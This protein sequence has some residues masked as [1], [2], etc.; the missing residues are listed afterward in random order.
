MKFKNRIVE[1][2]VE[3][4][5]VDEPIKEAVVVEPVEEPVVEKIDSKPTKFEEH[6]QRAIKNYRKFA[7]LEDDAQ[8]DIDNLDKD[9]IARVA[10]LSRTD[11]D[12][13]VEWLKESV[14]TEGQA[15][16]I[17]DMVNAN[18][19]ETISEDDSQG[20][21]EKTLDRIL[22]ANLRIN[23]RGGK[24]FINVLFE[25]AAGTGKTARIEEWAKKNS[26]NLVKV[27]AKKLDE[28]DFG[29]LNYN[30]E[31][32]Y[33]DKVRTTQ[34]DNLDKPR[35]V[36]FLDELNRA[37]QNIRATLLT[38]VNNH[39]I[40]DTKNGGSKYFENYLFTIAAINPYSS[41]YGT[42]PL[43][44]AE[45]S[46]Y[47]TIPVPNEIKVAK[48]YYNKYYDAAIEAGK[49]AGDDQAVL[50]DEGRKAIMNKLLDD[51]NFTFDDE[52]DE[53]EVMQ[54]GNQKPLNLRSFMKCL[55]ASDGTKA[56]FLSIWKN[57]CNDQKY[58]D[59]V[60][61]LKDYTDVADKANAAIGAGEEEKPKSAFAGK[62]DLYSKIYGNLGKN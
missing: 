29:V 22:K 39:E 36:L 37:N 33:A 42:K 15:E 23:S 61:I 19:D 43:D 9:V 56:D 3:T 45:Q 55:E 40:E 1:S 2:V 46:R 53:E 34:F 17:G 48:A 38:L 8:I 32:G 49:K 13:L 18:P 58:P 21:I 44:A 27:D 14:M 11:T 60:A 10:M 6:K 31:T 51:P 5:K 30:K 12:R 25:G 20:I 52:K 41:S 62:G 47:M 28:G 16:T 7:Q 24:E 26:I 57:F 4:A 54:N 50:E 35:S 59:V